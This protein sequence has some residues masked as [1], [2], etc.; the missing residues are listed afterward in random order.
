MGLFSGIKKAVK[1]VFKGIK[2]AFGSVMESV[3]KFTNSDIGKAIMLAAAVYTGGLAIA[4]GIQGWGAAAAEGAGFMGKF[5]A[6]AEGFITTMFNPITATENLMAGGGPL[7]ASQLAGITAPSVASG[8]A[9]QITAG[10]VAS[11]EMQAISNVAGG[12]PGAGTAVGPPSVLGGAGPAGVPG[13]IPGATPTLAGASTS[14]AVESVA[15]EPSWLEKA[16]NIGN[17]VLDVMDRP[18]IASMIQGYG[19][20]KIA[21]EERE[22][23]DRINR[24][25]DDPNNAFQKQMKGGGMLSGTIRRGN[26][27]SFLPGPTT[28]GVSTSG[29]MP[30]EP[31][32][33]G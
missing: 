21:E 24:Q 29:A 20:G 11:P 17:K 31:L 22:Y 30:G 3:S 19:E 32:P 8:A 15:A 18:V 10:A 23:G 14:R 16:A 9:N 1:G 28:P 27:P 12:V 6:G 26:Q 4:G 25:W 33:A 2:K 13:A 5:V 7:N